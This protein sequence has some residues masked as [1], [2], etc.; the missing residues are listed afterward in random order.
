MASSVQ[1][2]AV[3]KHRVDGLTMAF[4]SPTKGLSCQGA[5]N[6]PQTLEEQSHGSSWLLW[7]LRTGAGCGHRPTHRSPVLAEDTATPL[8]GCWAGKKC[9][10]GADT[11]GGDMAATSV[12]PTFPSSLPTTASAGWARASS[13]LHVRN[14][15][16]WWI[17]STRHRQLWWRLRCYYHGCDVCS[18]AIVLCLL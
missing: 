17:Y 13:Q 2:K 9:R 14:Q 10:T 3:D 18:L 15:V 11:L 16:T 7:T 8:I 4:F 1:P 12:I 6:G 5:G